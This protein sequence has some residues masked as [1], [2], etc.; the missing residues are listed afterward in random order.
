MATAPPA[1]EHFNESVKVTIE[2]S[3]VDIYGRGIA[4]IQVAVTHGQAT[5]GLTRTGADGTF[6][7]TK[8]TT[9]VGK[10]VI[11]ASAK[12]Y[13]TAEEPLTIIWDDRD[14]TIFMML[15]LEPKTQNEIERIRKEEAERATTAEEE[16][17][18]E[19]RQTLQANLDTIRRGE[20]T[21]LG[22]DSGVAER[23][24]IRD[25]LQE[26]GAN[27]EEIYLDLIEQR[28]KPGDATVVGGS[29]AKGGSKGD[30][31]KSEGYSIC[32]VLFASDRAKNFSEVPSKAFG[33]SRA[34]SDP[35][36][37]YGV[38][39]VSVPN[40]PMHKI[41]EVE[42]PP[43]FFRIEF[44]EDPKKHFVIQGCSQFKEAEFYKSISDRSKE[45][46]TDAVLLF[47]HGFMVTFAQAIYK[48]AQ[49]A[50]DL[51]FKGVPIC[52][53]WASKGLLREYPADESTSTWSI[54]HVRKVLEGIASLNDVKTIHV[55]AHSMGNRILLECLNEIAGGGSNSA[56]TKIGQLFL[57]APDI[58]TG[59]FNQIA[60]PIAGLST[61]T[62]L[63]ASSRDVALRASGRLHGDYARA[64]Y[65]GDA[66]VVSKF[67][68]TIDAS[69]VPADVLGHSYY[70]G[71]RTVLGDVYIL[72]DS[73]K[74]PPRFGLDPTS[75]NE[76]P[77]WIFVP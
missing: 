6:E 63:Y 73:G 70:G 21:S 36:L 53:T 44:A 77:Y 19:I 15:R 57:A 27:A 17:K 71:S 29:A 50:V 35:P 4:E 48:T 54:P 56:K 52:F 65:A 76:I 10:H 34:T 33:N 51:D 37:S 2:G 58:D 20:E 25:L 66:L 64:G 75:K 74:A 24:R 55:I 42:R 72:L 67:L 1:L 61:R 26:Y 31:K 3:V 69:A 5:V 68:D 46:H 13:D 9:K 32:R 18:R 30:D 47:I 28:G 16:R 11:K 12:A 43:S 38:C 59:R 39:E 45:A 49:I 62:T 23:D 14:G 60:Q 7:F 41:G 22:Y 8:L 40:R